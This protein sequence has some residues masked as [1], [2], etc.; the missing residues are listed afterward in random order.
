MADEKTI[1][2]QARES[3]PVQVKE[4]SVAAKAK[5]V[6]QPSL[7]ITPS[8]AEVVRVIQYPLATEKAVSGIETRNEITL[9]VSMKATKKQVM[10]EAEKLFGAKVKKVRTNIYAG[11][12]K[13]IV[14]F[15]KPGTASDVASKLKIV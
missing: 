3:K 9:V 10:L 2:M 7:A 11:R 12:K 1:A 8:S 4:K 13:A 5:P 6:E 15:V 14:K